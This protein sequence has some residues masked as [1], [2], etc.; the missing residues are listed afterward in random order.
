M[1]L[2]KND[3][4]LPLK[5]SG[6]KI[7]VVGPLANQTKVLLG[8]YNGSPTHTVSILDGMQKEFSGDTVTYVAGTQFLGHDAEPVPP[9]L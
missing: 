4:M 3:G 8:N 1:V 2:L 5:T 6:M 9:L 7:A